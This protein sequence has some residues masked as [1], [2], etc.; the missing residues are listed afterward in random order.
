MH[1]SAFR[2]FKV[3]SATI[4]MFPWAS[5]MSIMGLPWLNCLTGVFNLPSLCLWDCVT[6][7]HTVSTRQHI[8]HTTF[9]NRVATS[10]VNSMQL[11]MADFAPGAARWRTPT[12]NVV[13]RPTVAATWRTGLNIYN[14]FCFVSGLFTPL[15]ENMT[16]STKPEVHRGHVLHFHQKSIKPWHKKNTYRR[17]G[18]FWNVLLQTY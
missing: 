9:Y 8:W 1:P 11:E 3:H 4:S 6:V 17:F 15:C 18:E 16:S 2:Q 12:D 10:P 5:P 13:W 7:N 14:T